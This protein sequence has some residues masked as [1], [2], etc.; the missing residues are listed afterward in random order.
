MKRITGALWGVLICLPITFFFGCKT[1]KTIV[2][3][4]IKRT[5][6]STQIVKE[7]VNTHFSII[8][9]T[10][11]DEFTN[12]IREYTFET[13]AYCVADSLVHDANKEPM[14][15]IKADGSVVIH[16]GLKSIKETKISRKNEKKGVSVQKDSTV[17]KV[18]RTKVHATEQ[19][20]QKQRHVEQIAVSKP[21][22]FWQLII[23]ASI[24]FAIV[25]ALYYLYKRVPSVRNVVRKILD[26]IR[27]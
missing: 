3:E 1:K 13:P 22:D 23:G 20:K 7:N 19:H 25:I 8:D 11:I 9:T 6:D 26:R 12:I 4:S 15:E 27:K 16:H 18:A 5:Y 2:A 24:L 10:S 17:K 14:V 21:F